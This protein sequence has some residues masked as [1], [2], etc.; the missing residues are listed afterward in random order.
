MIRSEAA[1]SLRLMAVSTGLFLW[2]MHETTSHHQLSNASLPIGE[3]PGACTNFVHQTWME[4]TAAPHVPNFDPSHGWRLARGWPFFLLGTA[5]F[6]LLSLCIPAVRTRAPRALEAGAALLLAT[7]VFWLYMGSRAYISELGHFYRYFEPGVFL[8]QG[9]V[10]AASVGPLCEAIGPRAR[11]GLSLAILPLTAWAIASSFGMPSLSGVRADLDQTI[12]GRTADLIE[13]KCTHLVGDYYDVNPAQFHVN[14]VL[15]QRGEA[16]TVW[17]ISGCSRPTV[18]LWRGTIP[19]EDYV[20]AVI[21]DPARFEDPTRDPSVEPLLNHFRFPPLSPV[22]RRPTF[23]VMR[24]E[25]A[26]RIAD[27]TGD[28]AEVPPEGR[29]VE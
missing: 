20:V 17:G 14:M 19:R 21:S 9:A 23:W 16:R 3:W 1:V 2:I 25:S 6:G 24:P 8:A 7:L 12:G 4:L 28:A 10:L 29:A 5:F 22:E 13:S 18:R 15:Q 27:A 11:R 26:L